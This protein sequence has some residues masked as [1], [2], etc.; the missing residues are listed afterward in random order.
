MP[1]QAG[2]CPSP[3]GRGL[4]PGMSFEL[5]DTICHIFQERLKGA[6]YVIL[7]GSFPKKR[8]QI[9][10]HMSSTLTNSPIQVGA[11]TSPAVTHSEMHVHTSASVRHVCSSPY[12]ALRQHCKVVWSAGA[13]P[14]A[15]C[16]CLALGPQV[17]YPTFLS[18]CFL[19]CRSVYIRPSTYQVHYEDSMGNW[20]AMPYLA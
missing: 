3:G 4:V 1:R 16:R 18:L 20:P 19:I 7:W 13:G 9:L 6:F 15:F 10:Q 5:R 11:H 12:S 14:R 8:N 2:A 17:C